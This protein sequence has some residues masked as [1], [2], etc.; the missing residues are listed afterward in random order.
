MNDIW[1]YFCRHWKSFCFLVEGYQVGLWMWI[2]HITG[3]GFGL[4]EGLFGSGLA[5]PRLGTRRRA[6]PIL[7]LFG[8]S[9]K[10]LVQKCYAITKRLIVDFCYLRL[11]WVIL[12]GFLYF[13]IIY[14]CFCIFFFNFLF[15]EILILF[16]SFCLLIF[17][18]YF[19]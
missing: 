9:A 14:F 17:I 13:F 10:I 1:W 19:F 8:Q 4:K 18:F 16:S 11:G 12:I 6:I 7:G 15:S 2:R 3:F 5:Y